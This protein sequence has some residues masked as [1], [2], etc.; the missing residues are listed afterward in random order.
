MT[1]IFNGTTYAITFRVSS[2]SDPR[3]VVIRAQRM[4]TIGSRQAIWEEVEPLGTPDE[5]FDELKVYPFSRHVFEFVRVA[6]R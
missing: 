2:C 5:R 4:R 1:A 3:I 6:G